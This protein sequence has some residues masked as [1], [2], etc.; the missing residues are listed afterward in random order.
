[1]NV[2]QA[3]SQRRWLRFLLAGGVNTAASYAVYA[4]LLYAGLP[5]ALANLC[6]LAFGILFSFGTHATYVFRRHDGRRRLAQFLRYLACWTVLYGVN[7]LLIGG[8]MRLGLDAYGAGALAVLPMALLSYLAQQ[9]FV[10]GGH[11]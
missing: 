9:R 4:M 11:A 10:F 3:L 7:V 8:A 5:Y 2:A 1:M 6:G